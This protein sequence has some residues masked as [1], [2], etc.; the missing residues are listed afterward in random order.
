MNNLNS[1]GAKYRFETGRFTAELRRPMSALASSEL[2]AELETAV[3][4]GS[5]ERRNRILRCIA[6]LF[7]SDANRLSP[8]QIEVFDDV[9]LR[10]V[11]HAEP[12]ALSQLSTTL[13]NLTSAPEQTVRRLA[14]HESLAVAAPLLLKSK[15]LSD[16][17]LLEFAS[18]CGQQHLLAIERPTLSEVVTD[19]IVKHAGK[20]S[21]LVLARN[22][23]A[24]FSDQGFARLVE[25]ADHNDVI[26]ESLA[27][28]LD[29]PT[30]MLNHLLAKATQT[31]RARLLKSAPPQLRAK[32][33]AAIDI[34]AAQGS[35]T[36]SEPIDYA[37]ALS[38]VDGLNRTG[39]L[40]DSTVNRFAIQRDYAKLGAAL[41]VLSG[42][43]IETIELLMPDKDPMGLIVAARASRLNWQT[44]LAIINNRGMPPLS[45]DQVE[46]SKSFFETLYVSTAQYTIRFEPPINRTAEATD[47]RA[48]VAARAGR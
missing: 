14:C 47:D 39:K 25:A 1:L 9:L 35:A 21:L 46:K 31:V 10:L 45:K 18:H 2:I 40:N 38:L 5:P 41:A 12:Q 33:Q 30:A 32:I 48:P 36:K 34:I 27:L 11:E 6:D 3:R 26:A 7:A 4:D 15:V 17:N 19:V 42:A 23:A 22:A 24:R 28:R 20:D 8:S 43:A 44:A 16:A 13:A 29:L 37:A